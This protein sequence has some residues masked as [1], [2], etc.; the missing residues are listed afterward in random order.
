MIIIYVFAYFF[1]QKIFFLRTK[2]SFM[3]FLYC[4]FYGFCVTKTS[5]LKISC[6]LD[7][8]PF[9]LYSLQSRF[10]SV[11][12]NILTTKKE[13]RKVN[14]ALLLL[15]FPPCCLPMFTIYGHTKMFLMLLMHTSMFI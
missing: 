10:L 2:K 6:G 12:N 3:V 1:C 8:K 14:F 5:S 15:C 11:L 7:F 4:R 13:Q 9:F